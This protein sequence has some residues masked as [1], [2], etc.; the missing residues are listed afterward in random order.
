MRIAGMILGILGG[1]F[2][3]GGALI[4]MTAGGVGSAFAARGASHAVVLGLIALAFGILGVVA[5]AVT[6]RRPLWAGILMIISAIGGIIA[7]SGGF[8]IAG[9]LLLAGGIM[10]LLG[11]R[12]LRRSTLQPAI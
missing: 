6:L 5:G 10:A 7:I 12:E 9:I 4:V 2:G 11:R 3:I 8:I 1:L